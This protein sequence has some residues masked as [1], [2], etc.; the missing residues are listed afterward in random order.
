MSGMSVGL[1][2]AW[3][4]LPILL[5]LFLMTIRGWAAATAAF[6]GLACAVPVAIVV[7]G[8]GGAGDGL[9]ASAGVAMEAG[10]TAAA[11]LWII[12]PA[13]CIFELLSRHGAFDVLRQALGRLTEDPRLLAILVA[14]FFA[15]FLEGSAGFGT[16]VALAAP[17]L[18][19]LGFSAVRAV[20][21]VLIGHATGV[22]FGAIG[23]PVF[24]QAAL[25][26]L[27]PVELAAQTALLHLVLCTALV[28][29]VYWLAVPAGA[30]RDSAWRRA[31][32]VP[33]AA[34]CFA[35]PFFVLAVRV[36]PEVPTLLGALIGGAAFAAVLWA[37]RPAAVP[38]TDTDAG[39]ID[40]SGLGRL[41]LP[42]GLLI[43]L[44]LATRLIGPVQSVLQGVVWSW[45]MGEVYGGLFQPLYHPGTLLFI[46]FAVG[47]MLMG[48]RP[49]DLVASGRQAALRL[50][51]VVVALVG[52]LAVARLMVHAGMVD[53][54]AAAV[55]SAGGDGWPVLA[56]MIGVLGTFVT[57]SATASNILFTDF[58][59]ETAELLGLPL[60]LMVAA[61]CFGAAVGNMVCPHNVI[62]G[63]AT[64]G[65]AHREGEVL[66]RT[67][68]IGIG[69]GAA[70]G[71]LVWMLV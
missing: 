23:T 10:H 55:A 60:L 61:Q 59:A 42:Y 19:S 32:V 29:A 25:T 38:D 28:G 33:L 41:L 56:P 48:D 16:P 20:T 47:G 4:A 68:L 5:I 22:S 2:A 14:W 26:G 36:G 7:F 15:L 71:V 57:G 43:V 8:F 44:I 9:L 30:G 66:R 54:L 65:L 35:L 13:L 1:Q 34:L 46:S 39:A 51:P 31:W 24:A 27:A 11:I 6:A 50:L 63:A 18:V 40:V 12:F 53:S 70:G 45:S 62:A 3:A 67:V 64:V 37:T 17:L 21:I 52:M 58:Q 69:Y 49:G